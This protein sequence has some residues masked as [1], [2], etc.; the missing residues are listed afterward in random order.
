[1]PEGI[2]GAV[3]LRSEVAA[4]AQALND[5]AYQGQQPVQILADVKSQLGYF[6]GLDG[7]FTSGSPEFVAKLAE[8]SPEAFQ[9]IAPRVFDTYAQNNPEGY[10]AYV[11]Q[12]VMGHMNQADVPLAFKTLQFMLPRLADS[13]EK[14]AVIAEFEKIYGWTE[15]LKGLAAKPVGPAVKKE[16]PNATLEQKTAELAAQELDVTRQSWN[17][18]ATRFGE[19]LIVKE[20]ARLAGKTALTDEQKNSIRS[21]VAEE[22]D[23]RLA[24]NP[25]FGQAMRGFLQNKDGEGYK[26]RLHSEYQKLIPGAVSRAYSDVVTS[27]PAQR[28]AAKPSQK[29]DVPR[30]TESNAGYRPVS[31]Y[32]VGQVDM[33]RTSPKD[34]QAGRLTLKDSSKVLV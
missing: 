29:V 5:P 14:Q 1:M 21:K 18:T 2:K 22:L 19:D 13:P 10:S 8:A 33:L 7:L 27:K 15:S 28:V 25:A 24:G 16:D 23:A 31:K 26:R 12:A 17:M 6:H 30:G 4:L 20:S 32:P 34:H 9:K 3:A 11:A